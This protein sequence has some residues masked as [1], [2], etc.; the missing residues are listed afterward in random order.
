MSL[1][2]EPF[3]EPLHLASDVEDHLRQNHPLRSVPQTHQPPLWVVRVGGDDG[4]LRPWH[5]IY[6]YSIESRLIVRV[7]YDSHV[8]PPPSIPPADEAPNAKPAP[9][10]GVSRA[11]SNHLLLLYYSQALS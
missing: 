11:I 6:V 9:A 5:Y 10:Q 1:K 2:Y 7:R 8:P 3:S 4:E